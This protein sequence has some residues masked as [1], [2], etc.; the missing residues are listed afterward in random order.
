MDGKQL[1]RKSL[2]WAEAPSAVVYTE[3][4]IIGQMHNSVQA[5][6]HLSCPVALVSLLSRSRELHRNPL[7]IA[8]VV[9]THVPCSRFK[10]P[11]IF[12]QMCL[13]MSHPFVLQQ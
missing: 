6:L 7:T 8:M 13:R 9:E 10:D 11:D 4:Y 3:P 2:T 1:R 5:R 12:L